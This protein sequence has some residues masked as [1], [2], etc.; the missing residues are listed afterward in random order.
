MHPERADGA[1]SIQLGMLMFV[2]ANI[3]G[4]TIQITTL[5]L[6][7]LSTLQAVRAS[8]ELASI[9]P[10]SLISSRIVRPRFQHHL[11][12]FDPG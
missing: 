4:S 11:R 10:A 5:P 9:Y 1:D 8:P 7:V 6:P 2:V 3:V 12:N